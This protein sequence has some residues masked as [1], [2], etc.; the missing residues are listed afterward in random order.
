M[1]YD[2]KE[3]KSINVNKIGIWGMYGNIFDYCRSYVLIGIFIRLYVQR[4]LQT[5]L[6][7]MI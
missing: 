6:F 7:I 3:F 4:L 2:F 5:G 1:W